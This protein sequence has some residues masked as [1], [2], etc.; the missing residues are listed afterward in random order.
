MRKYVLIL[1]LLRY[2]NTNKLQDTPN[3]MW[4]IPLIFNLAIA[5]IYDIESAILTELNSAIYWLNVC[6]KDGVE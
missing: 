1:Y 3:K 5:Y 6:H 4:E 2:L